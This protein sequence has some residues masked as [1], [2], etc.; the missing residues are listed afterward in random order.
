MGCRYFELQY[1]GKLTIDDVE[2]ICFTGR[3]NPT[4]KV[5]KQIKD[6]KINVY[7]IKGGELNEM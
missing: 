2:S 1:H 5:L 7:K 4:E 3:D 6:R